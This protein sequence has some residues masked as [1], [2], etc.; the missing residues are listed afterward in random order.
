MKKVKNQKLVIFSFVAVLLVGILGYF[1]F[2]QLNNLGSTDSSAGS[3]AKQ[4]LEGYT[5]TTEWVANTWNRYK[6]RVGVTSS[7]YWKYTVTGTQPA[8]VTPTV[9]VTP[10]TSLNA[11]ARTNTTDA[12][13]EISLVLTPLERCKEKTTKALNLSGTFTPSKSG[14]TY[15]SVVYESTLAKVVN[16]TAITNS[17][18][19]TTPV[20]NASAWSYI[21]QG[22]TSSCYTP[23]VTV[24]RVGTNQSKVELVLTR[25]QNYV[26]GCPKDLRKFSVTTKAPQE[27]KLTNFNLKYSTSIKTNVATPNPTVKDDKVYTSNG[28]TLKASYA[29][30]NSWKYSITGNLPNSCYV[31][32]PRVA[33]S[34]SMPEKVGVILEATTVKTVR[35]CPEV[36]KSYEYSSTFSASEGAQ[37]TFEAILPK[38]VSTVEKR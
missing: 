7:G 27:F 34:K 20:K 38:G 15:F 9:V 32:A 25:G 4:N 2:N 36:V 13:S 8:C 14:V 22:Q 23:S 6:E 30:A 18:F 28:F 24:S 12:N 10:T 31:A 3:T 37:I 1:V 11:Y 35:A 21:T 5:L 19:T 17:G 16:K 29:G 26:S 33:V